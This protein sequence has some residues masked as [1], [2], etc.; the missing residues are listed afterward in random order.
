[1]EK[2]ARLRNLISLV[3]R[4]ANKNLIGFAQLIVSELNLNAVE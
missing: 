1:M 3:I 4:C 2:S